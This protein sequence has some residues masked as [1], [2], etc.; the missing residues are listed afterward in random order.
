MVLKLVKISASVKPVW[1][2]EQNNRISEMLDKNTSFTIGGT[3]NQSPKNRDCLFASILFPNYRL[4]EILILHEVSL[5]DS[6]TT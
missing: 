4:N 6:D 5:Q 2:N 3:K 1:R